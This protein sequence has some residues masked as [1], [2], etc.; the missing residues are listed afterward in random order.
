MRP[1]ITLRTLI[2][3][4]WKKALVTWVLVL[5]E[6]LI[7]LVMPLVIGWAVDDLIHRDSR[8][9]A[10]L[11]V[12]CMSLL[13]VGAGRRFYDTRVYS[14]IYKKVSAEMVDRE[15]QKN[16]ALS[17]VSARM[18][19]FTEFVEF[20]ENALPDIFTH[21][22]GLAGTLLI[23]VFMDIRV[24]LACIGGIAVTALIYMLSKFKMMHLNKG[25]NDVFEQQVDVLASG[26]SRRLDTYLASLMRWNIRLSDLETLNF[27][28]TWMVLT[29]VLLFTLVVTASSG[30]AGFG[31][32]LT[33]V[34]YVFGFIESILAFPLYYQQMVRLQEIA[35]RLG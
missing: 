30:T 27:S 21:L 29:L 4:F 9:L 25:Q 24:F 17:R 22:V 34:M 26:S 3:R 13:V 6:A 28:L 14:G 5:C 10:Q 7:L 31:H 18:N 19:L 32:I 12:L 11:A 23:I 16:T 1:K 8:G 33:M 2:R 20:L 35:G 15:K